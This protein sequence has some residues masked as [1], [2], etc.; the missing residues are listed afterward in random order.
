MGKRSRKA[1]AGGDSTGNGRAGAAGD[2]LSD[3]AVD[4]PE[5]AGEDATGDVVRNAAESVRGE[6]RGNAMED[7]TADER[8]NA[9]ANP[10]VNPRVNEGANGS[11][12]PGV[13]P[14]EDEDVNARRNEPEDESGNG[15]QDE[16]G[17]TPIATPGI[18]F[19]HL[20]DFW[21]GSVPVWPFSPFRGQNV[22][23]GG[24]MILQVYS[25]TQVRSLTW[26]RRHARVLFLGLSRPSG[27]LAA[28]IQGLGTRN[29]TPR[30]AWPKPIQPTL[31][32]P[33]MPP[34]ATYSV[35][36]PQML[37]SASRLIRSVRR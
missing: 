27:P 17:I 14:A 20:R 33:T 23:V 28:R 4:A 30:W 21:R 22:P 8:P 9:S 6:V 29:V 5:D 13:N 31:P 1:S 3:A 2:A 26:C 12:N 10:G 19:Q 37:V 15:W 24:G 36:S 25:Y 35:S 7:A 11:A 16:L 18:V 34:P 32:C